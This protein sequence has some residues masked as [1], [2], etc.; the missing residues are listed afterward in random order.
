MRAW[1]NVNVGSEGGEEIKVESGDGRV[2][3]METERSM[4]VERTE[5]VGR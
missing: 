4:E 5:D 3:E 2:M 1:R